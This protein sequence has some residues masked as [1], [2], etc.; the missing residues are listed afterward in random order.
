MVNVQAVVEDV[1]QEEVLRK[2]LSWYRR[3][4]S[5]IGV[6]GKKGNSY[7]RQS[8]RGFSEASR[9]LPH[10]VIT[11]LDR[12]ACAPQLIAEWINFER[13]PDMLFRIAEKEIDAWILSDRE[14]FANFVGVPASRIPTDTETLPDPKLH[15]INLA[16]RSRK[17]VMKDLVPIG[18]GTQGPGYNHVLQ[19]FVINYWNPDRASANNRSLRK[20]VERLKQYLL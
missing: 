17:K 18:S 19:D 13:H 15:I 3:D 2:L 4:I 6:S 12:N 11:D 10:I 9:F 16:R 5:L 20:S 7:I 1:L 14:E 8:I